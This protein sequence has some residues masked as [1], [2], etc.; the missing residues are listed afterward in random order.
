MRV[1]ELRQ[2]DALQQGF[3]GSTSTAPLTGSPEA[4]HNGR[5]LQNCVCELANQRTRSRETC[6]Q[7]SGLRGF[8]AMGGVVRKSANRSPVDDF[9][10]MCEKPPIPGTFPRKQPWA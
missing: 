7:C 8:K 9:P 1:G 10:R 3:R 2:T 4:R 6:P 5:N